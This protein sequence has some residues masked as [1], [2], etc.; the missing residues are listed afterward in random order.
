MRGLHSY[1]VK[2]GGQCNLPPR[3]ERLPLPAVCC[4]GH[5]CCDSGRC[6]HQAAVT[7]PLQ[8]PAQLRHS[9]AHKGGVS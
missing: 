2:L 4:G 7:A 8:L 3:R 6:S 9:S 5:G 1:G